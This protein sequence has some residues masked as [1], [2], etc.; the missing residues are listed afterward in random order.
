M[1][2]IPIWGKNDHPAD[3]KKVIVEPAITQEFHMGRIHCLGPK[4][5]LFFAD[6]DEDD[7]EDLGRIWKL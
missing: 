7:L 6:L 5:E 1:Y 3:I 4:D 2:I